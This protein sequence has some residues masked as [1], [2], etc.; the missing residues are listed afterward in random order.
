M[1]F[2]RGK[3]STLSNGRVT[4]RSKHYE[5]H[6]FFFFFFKFGIEYVDPEC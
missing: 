2:C 6:V 3:S 4:R 5:F 1:L